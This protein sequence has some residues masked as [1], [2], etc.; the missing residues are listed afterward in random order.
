M[1]I[2]DFTN[3]LEA[4]YGIGS[5]STK[6][7]NEYLSCKKISESD[8]SEARPNHMKIIDLIEDGLIDYKFI[9]EELLRW[10]PD[11]ELGK[12]INMYDLDTDGIEESCTKSKE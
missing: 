12:L 7:L 3:A 1:N 8:E 9:A 10:M 6:V 5:E 11:D 4:K 2:S